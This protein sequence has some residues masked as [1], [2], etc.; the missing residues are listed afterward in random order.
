MRQ[1]WVCISRLVCPALLAGTWFDDCFPSKA[2]RGPTALHYIIQ[3]LEIS[4]NKRH[5]P[6]ILEKKQLAIVLAQ[7]PFNDISEMAMER[8]IS[9]FLYIQ[10]I[11][12]IFIL[13][14]HILI[15]WENDLTMT[16]PQRSCESQGGIIPKVTC[17]IRFIQ[18]NPLIPHYFPNDFMAMLVRFSPVSNT[19]HVVDD[20]Y[21]DKIP[22]YAHVSEFP[23]HILV[24]S[25]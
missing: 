1:S 21:P 20:I 7:N 2:Y 25:P 23:P 16:N 5:Y 3:I 4:W 10:P 11:H 17:F 12:P 13:D 14:S 15:H 24:K 6:W 9:D 8:D 18:W 22:C 19:S